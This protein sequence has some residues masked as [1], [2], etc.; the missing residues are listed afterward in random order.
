MEF[1]N[2]FLAKTC[3]RLPC[4]NLYALSWFQGSQPPTTNHSSGPFPN[5]EERPQLS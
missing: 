2:A 5:F 3:Y 4:N 1:S